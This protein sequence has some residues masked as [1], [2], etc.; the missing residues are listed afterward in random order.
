MVENFPTQSTE[1]GSL[2]RREAERKEVMRMFLFQSMRSEQ[3]AEQFKEDTTDIANVEFTRA[4]YIQKTKDSANPN[5]VMPVGGN[6]EPKENLRK[7]GLRESV[8][9][10]HVR[11]TIQSFRMLDTAQDYEFKHPKKGLLKRRSHFAV[12]RL[13]PG[14]IP[15]P[16]EE[17]D[18]IA[19]FPYLSIEQTQ[20]LFENGTVHTEQGD[21]PLLESLAPG[22]ARSENAQVH[23]DLSESRVKQE[24]LSLHKLTEANKKLEVLE[25]LLDISHSK[26]SLDDIARIHEKISR[27]RENIN[28][29][30]DY[31]FVRDKNALEADTVFYRV[32]ELWRDVAPHFNQEQVVQALSNSN[33]EALVKFSTEGRYNAET[34]KGIPTINLLFPLLA[35]Q[36]DKFNIS[37][38]KILMQNPQMRTLLEAVQL[39]RKRDA[40]VEDIYRLFKIEA[41]ED[42]YTDIGRSIDTFFHHLKSEAQVPDEVPIDQM[43]EVKSKDFR[44]LVNI[45]LGRDKFYFKGK[46]EAVKRELR[47][48]AQRKLVLMLML[49]QSLA[50]Q[51]KRE[52]GGVEVLDRIEYRLEAPGSSGYHRT[53]RLNGKN[54]EVRIDRDEKTVLSTLRKM[55]VRDRMDNQVYSDIFR[56]AYIFNGDDITSED[57]QDVDLPIANKET[58]RVP[59]IVADLLY[60]L[61]LASKLEGGRLQILE[62]KIFGSGDKAQSRS[63]GGGGDIR[64]AKFYLRHVSEDGVERLREV[65]VFLNEADYEAKHADQDR[66]AMARLFH[67]QGLRSVIELLYPAEIYGDRLRPIHAGKVG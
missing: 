32:Q 13:L 24:V 56:E 6:L 8:E 38:R 26:Y 46:S 1:G 36:K 22:S 54:H 21:Y 50:E 19:A 55:L 34:G 23:T 35:G 11:P 4:L 52:R 63:V 25:R 53:L 45:A 43:N 64:M 7:A 28:Q 59:Q 33:L 62:L 3:L 5:Q 17:A 66:Y 40:H 44:T 20:E 15:Y 41:N 2:E 61:Q 10:M 47:W 29:I 65:Q 58:M 49:T 18:N 60:E 9:E 39:L 27:Y 37:E 14:D 51:K 16:L 57:T 30:H 67:T 12:G 48:E 42:L 31:T